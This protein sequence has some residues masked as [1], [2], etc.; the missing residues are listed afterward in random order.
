MNYLTGDG[1]YVWLAAVLTGTYGIPLLYNFYNIVDQL[2]E[3][4]KNKFLKPNTVMQVSSGSW[5]LFF[6][7]AAVLLSCVWLARRPGENVRRGAM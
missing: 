7:H 4:V 1:T 3:D 6:T 5:L 2:Q